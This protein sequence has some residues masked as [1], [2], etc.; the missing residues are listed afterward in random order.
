MTPEEELTYYKK[1]Y[2]RE[3][4]ARKEAESILE[5]KAREL[6]LTNKKL[7]SLNASLEQNL[8]ERTERIKE[9]EEQYRKL[10]E[11]A[12]DV[13]FRVDLSGNFTYINPT[14]ARMANMG[15]DELIGTNF[16]SLVEPEFHKPMFKLYKDQLDNET[17]STYIEYRIISQD[18]Q[19]VWLGQ[20]VQLIF[21]NGFP[22][23]YLAVARDITERVKSDN[24]LKRSNE[25]YKKLFEG[26][27]DG[28]IRFDADRNFLEWNSKIESMLGYSSE[29]LSGMHISKIMHPDDIKNIAPFYQKLIKDGYYT[30]YIGRIVSKTGKIIYIEVNSTATYENGIANGSIDNVR[31]ISGRVQLEKAIIRSEEKYR[32]ILE[33]LELGLLEVNQQDIITKV[34]PSFCKLT[35]YSEEDLLGK[36][37]NDLLLHPDSI[38]TMQDE[39]KKRT[40]GKA[41]VY[42]VQIKQ[43]SG[44]YKWIIISGAP[45]YDEYGEIQG[46]IGVHLD[47]S[48][49]KQMQNDLKEANKVAQASSKAKEIFLANMSHEIRTPLN[50]VIGLSNL[51]K[52]T[53]LAPQQIEYASNINNAAQ[54]LLLLVNDIL[55]ITKIES[56]KLELHNSKFNLRKTLS[57]TLS[58]TGYLAEKKNLKINLDI[59]PNLQ[60]HYLGDELK[61][62]QI[63]INLINNAIKFTA[64]GTVTIRV[65]C[66]HSE[67]NIHQIEIKVEDTGKGIAPEALSTIFE[68]FNQ[69]DASISKDFGGTGLGLSI[70]KKLVHLLGGD[71]T[72]KS[73][74]NVGTT[75]SFKLELAG[76]TEN[77]SEAINKEE[78]VLDWSN[79]KI[80]VAED[81]P[82]NQFVIE[83][84]IENWNGTID[85][86][87]NGKEAINML[88]TQEYDIVL[89]DLQMPEMDG[90]TATKFIRQEMNLNLPIIAFTANAMKTEKDRCFAVGMDDY[91]SKPFQE[92]Q[93][94]S[95]II[96]LILKKAENKE[97]ILNEQIVE[98]IDNSPFFSIQ[99]LHDL[100]RGNKSFIQKMLLIF[101]EDGEQQVNQIE[102]ETDPT[103]ISKIAHKIKPS[104][105]Y[106]SNDYMQELVRKI[107]NKEF[108][109]EPDL[110]ST[111]IDALKKLI[112]L[113]DEAHKEL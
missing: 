85:L 80:L 112:A 3:K 91:I 20:N 32:G 105:D 87:S 72:V 67:N 98:S 100:S 108:T 24:E 42:E 46:T 64:E 19:E 17:E 88:S 6:Y 70:C 66:L 63:L 27:F 92:N 41:S 82:I 53:D 101:C 110:L 47:I 79:V 102:E 33:N 69:E 12:N 21:Q 84:T 57:T 55:D 62:C 83:S 50:A 106:L 11:T 71:L 65:T 23:E 77:E 5:S 93:L 7:L 4:A 48:A 111:F 30:N 15:I 22:I 103:V 96:H 109:A 40:E 99:R 107:E 113:A 45:F 94:Q 51:L 54:S 44:G 38:K 35:E 61:I 37:P 56:G 16:V 60:E 10:V 90:I 104:I 8:H 75:F 97:L 18:K 2:Q 58:S 1:A 29:E 34:Y 86:A 36:N 68:D 95:K 43:K 31:D 73:E 39:N 25:K 28:V 9:A 13:I 89:M 78:P 14:G 49:Q 59:D 26:G 76:L 81:N 74:L 52:Q